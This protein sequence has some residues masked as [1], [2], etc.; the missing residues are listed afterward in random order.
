MSDELMMTYNLKLPFYSEGIPSP[1]KDSCLLTLFLTCIV[2]VY[3]VY[4]KSKGHDFQIPTQWIP[5]PSHYEIKAT[6]KCNL[7]YYLVLSRL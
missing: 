5:R 3:G 2:L 6:S 1:A 7:L 4:R